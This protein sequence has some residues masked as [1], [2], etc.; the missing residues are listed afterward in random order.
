MKGFTVKIFECLG[1]IIFGSAFSCY[2]MLMVVLLLLHDAFC[3]YTY[4]MTYMMFTLQFWT[5]R[6]QAAMF[7][8]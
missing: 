1:S 4:F 7:V 8:S 6:L 5:S 2:I 3:H